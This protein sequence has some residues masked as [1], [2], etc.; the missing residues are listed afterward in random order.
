VAA[1][2]RRQLTAPGSVPPAEQ[3]RLILTERAAQ[4]PPAPVA[5]HTET[6]TGPRSAVLGMGDARAGCHR[7]R[8]GG[9]RN[10]DSAGDLETDPVQFHRG[11][12]RDAVRPLR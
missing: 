12:G 11:C 1:A 10:S 6:P 9:M 3:R 8:E 7:D 5:A 2:V 4:L